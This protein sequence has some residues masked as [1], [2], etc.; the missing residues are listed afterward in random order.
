MSN[1]IEFGKKR[2]T[3][4]PKAPDGDLSAYAASRRIAQHFGIAVSTD[5]AVKL[6]MQLQH[7]MASAYHQGY[8]DAASWRQLAVGV[9]VDGDRVIVAARGGNEGARALCTEL[10]GVAK[11]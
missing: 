11:V 10:L 2:K 3:P 6:E 5:D 9:R 4:P 8:G 7:M 1:I